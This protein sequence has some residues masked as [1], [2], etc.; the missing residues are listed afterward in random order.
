MDAFFASW[1]GK[2]MH[3]KQMIRDIH[4]M[5][6]SPHFKFE[7]LVQALKTRGYVVDSAGI[8]EIIPLNKFTT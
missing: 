6:T 4:S 2:P 1:D 8:V 7:D 3:I 5:Q